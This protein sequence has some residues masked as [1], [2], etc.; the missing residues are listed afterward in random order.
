MASVLGKTQEQTRFTKEAQRV[1]NQINRLFFDSKTGLYRDGIGTNHSSLHANMFPLTFGIVPE[2]NKQ[3]VI[4]FIHSRGMVCSVY[5][6]QFLGDAVYN[7]NDAAYGLQLLSSTEMRSWYNMIRAGS[8]ISMEAWDNKYK[9]D[10]DWNHIWG[11]AAG[12]LIARKL[13]GIEPVEAGFKKIRIKPQPATLGHAEVK[14]P[15]IRGDIRVAFDNQ[16]NERF[17]LNVEIPANSIAE[18]W[19]PK[20]SAKY[21]LT[22]DNV[23]QKGTVEGGFVKVEVGSGEHHFVI[24][25]K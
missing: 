12:N 16:P 6:A 5:G 7:A 18:V 25:I 2:K 22:V 11:A 17:V 23:A 13:M 15:S 4:D 24:A 20:L 1:K 21:K 14:I 19:L 3:K 10:Q 9:S 8:T